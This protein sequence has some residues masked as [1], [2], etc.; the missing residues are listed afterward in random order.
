MNI[1]TI[2]LSYDINRNKQC[3]VVNVSHIY[4]RDVKHL[5]LCLTDGGEKLVLDSSCTVTA[6]YVLDKGNELVADGVPCEVSEDGTVLAPFDT[7]TLAAVSGVLRIEVIINDS[8][9][10]LALPYP[11]KVL[12]KD[13][14]LQNSHITPDSKGTIPELLEEVKEQLERVEGFVNADEVNEIIDSK[15]YATAIAAKQDKLGIGN[16]DELVDVSSAG[17]MKRS[18]YSVSTNKNVI[19]TKDSAN[20][21]IPSAKAI[22]EYVEENSG[23]KDYSELENKPSI[24][25]VTLQGNKTSADLG[26]QDS[27]TAGTNIEINSGTISSKTGTFTYHYDNW[28]GTADYPIINGNV[29]WNFEQG[30]IDLAQSNSTPYWVT[31]GEY[32]TKYRPTTYYISDIAKLN[33]APVNQIV[34]IFADRGI[35]PSNFQGGLLFTSK[36]FGNPEPKGR[37]QLVLTLDNK[38]YV[39]H[40]FIDGDVVGWARIGSE[41]VS[42]A[43]NSNGTIT[44]TDSDGNTFTTTGASVIGA[45]GFSPTATV[46]KSGNTSIITITDKNGTTTATVSDG[47]KGDKGDTGAQGPQGDD[48]VLTAQDK[49]DIANI[50]LSELPTTQEVLYGNTSD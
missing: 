38:L 17:E 10:T 14:I 48:Y 45:D 5:E 41:V 4:N 32:V 12:I 40:Y 15:G 26:L 31:L 36:R 27:L 7:K 30:Y 39:R 22:A 50:V 18:G 8:G 19:S 20:K 29:Q 33:N 9:K 47:A 42:G 2:K 13:T 44:F 25:N 37:T 46:T 35:L 49:S 3:P 6:N 23:T 11:V 24:N 21:F 1:K 28:S 34:N 43:V 16:K